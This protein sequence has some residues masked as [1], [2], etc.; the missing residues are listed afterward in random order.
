MS[1]PVRSYKSTCHSKVCVNGNCQESNECNVKLT[2]G[3]VVATTKAGQP[4]APGKTGSTGGYSETETPKPA[5]TATDLS[6]PALEGSSE[7]GNDPIGDFIRW[8]QELLDGLFN[9]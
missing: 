7:N 9:R 3:K 6:L 1:I 5:T 2:N 4:G 8:I